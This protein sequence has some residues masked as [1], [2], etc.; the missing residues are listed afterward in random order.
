MFRVYTFLEDSPYHGQFNLTQLA[1]GSDLFSI[2]VNGH[3][4]RNPD[5]HER[6]KR[7]QE[8]SLNVIGH[9]PS[10]FDIY[11]PEASY[12]KATMLRKTQSGL[13]EWSSKSK[14]N[15][16]MNSGLVS[17][18]VK[19]EHD[20]NKEQYNAKSSW[21]IEHSYPVFITA[22]VM[23]ED[24]RLGKWRW[25][26]GEFVDLI[27]EDG[28]I[29]KSAEDARKYAEYTYPRLLMKT[30]CTKEEN[31]AVLDVVKDFIDDAVEVRKEPTRAQKRKGKPGDIVS[32]NWHQVLERLDNAEHYKEAGI[33]FHDRFMNVDGLRYTTHWIPEGYRKLMGKKPTKIR[34]I[35][36]DIKETKYVEHDY[37]K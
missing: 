32:V 36:K 21:T 17:S 25:D 24:Y 22:L 8:L 5:Q 23:S 1:R 20:K 4:S 12:R 11:A 35:E 37:W 15:S 28:R 33:T 34:E 13:R 14:T 29:L 19:V 2:I 7:A 6:K 27:D 18:R 26:G 31:L 9:E 10:P 16:S 30:I 3:E